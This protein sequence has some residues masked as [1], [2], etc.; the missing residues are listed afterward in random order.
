MLALLFACSGDTH[1]CDTKKV[2]TNDNPAQITPSVPPEKE[3]V[4]HKVCTIV[5]VDYESMC[6]IYTLDCEGVTE[7]A[8]VC[9]IKPVGKITNPP[10]PI[11]IIFDSKRDLKTI[12]QIQL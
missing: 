1:Q 3:N 2:I 6:D 10:R 7:Y 8:L 12:H 9:H 5:R 11:Q 4:P